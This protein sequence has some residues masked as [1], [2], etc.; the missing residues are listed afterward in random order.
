MKLDSKYF[1]SIRVSSRR[2][3]GAK[4]KETRA[5]LCQWKGCDKP[6]NHKAPKGRGRD[7]EYFHFCMDH[8]RQYNQDY[9]YF[10]GMSDTEVSN[11]RKD[12]LTGHRPTWKTGANAWAHGTR[13]GARTEEAAERVA[14]SSARMTRKARS[15]RTE[16][17]TFRRQLKPLERKSLKVMDLADDASREDIKT[18]FK[19]LVKIHHPDANGGDSRSEEKLREILQAY[20]YLKQSGLA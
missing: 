12:A 11:F 10:D 1:D 16:P 17:S 7:G 13:D 3:T 19:E 15:S 6:G 20:N 9:N 5:P 4:K 18:R 2:S 14:A 8:V